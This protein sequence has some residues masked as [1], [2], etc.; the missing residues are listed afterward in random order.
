MRVSP[1][2]RSKRMPGFTMIELMITL[3]IVGILASIALP[4]YFESVTRSKITDGLA[5]LG[6]YQGKMWDYY[7]DH[8][9]TFVNPPLSTTCGLGAA[10]VNPD[11]YFTITCGPPVP[12]DSTFTVV[13]T[14]IAAKGM[15]GFTYSITQ[16]NAKS[17][18][19]VPAGW[20]LPAPNNCWATRK[21]GSC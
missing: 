6:S 14:G 1:P 3:A 5:K 15:G 18:V 13:A 10:P 11:D 2:K 20:S 4:M 16:T 21:D 8:A 9:S 17:T 7:N 19:S 12:T